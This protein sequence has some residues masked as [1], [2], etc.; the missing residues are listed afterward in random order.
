MKNA[1]LIV[2][3]ND[4]KSTI[5]LLDNIKDYKCLEEIVV[6]DNASKDEEKDKLKKLGI[7]K[8]HVIYNE[9]NEGYSKAINIGSKYLIN[10]YEKI[11]LIISN[12]DIVIMSED[13]IKRMSDVL[14]RE[15]VGLVGPQVLELGG[16]YRGVKEVGPMLDFWLSTP[17]VKNFISD[18]NYLY[19]DSYYQDEVSYV[20]VISSCFFM[21]SS[22]VMQRINY[23]DENI[24]LYYEDYILGKKVRNLGLKVA[25]LNDVKIKHL[26]SV[27]VDKIIKNID[28]YKLLKQSQF[29]YHTTYNKINK[30]ER[31]L[32]KVNTC[33][34]IWVR[35]IKDM[36]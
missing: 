5:H 10:K 32:L 6:V 4:Y 27:S 1:F 34:G 16:V 3:C 29:Y 17:I 11:N 36:F 31:M 30:L 33:L 7:P 12:S 13:D 15:D 24:F 8:V 21:I 26:Y 20:D 9:Q 28:K 14:N 22:E 23:M 35:K 25:I 2:N 19:K 18:S